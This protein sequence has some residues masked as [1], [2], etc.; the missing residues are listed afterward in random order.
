MTTHHSTPGPPLA[1]WEPQGPPR[2]S[3]T[4][5]RALLAVVLVLALT[6]L[7]LYVAKA[8]PFAR[9]GA[10]GPDPAVAAQARGFLADWSHDRLDAAGARTTH[11]AEASR[12][13]GSFTS[14]LEI[15][16]PRLTAGVPREAEGGAVEVPFTARMPVKGLGTW[17][18]TSRMTLRQAKDGDG[19]R[20]L[21][22]WKPGLV[23]PRLSG[24]AKFRLDREDTSE[25][26]AK[27]RH[28]KPLTSAAAPSLAPVL[29]QLG[30]GGA[31]PRGAIRLV[32]RTSGEVLRTE[33]R[34][35]AKEATDKVAETTLDSTW[36]TAA[37]H[38]LAAEP[39]DRNASLVAL[40]GDT[41]EILAVA[42][43]PATGFNR[44]VSGTYAPGST[45][46][47]VTSSALL[48]KGVVRPDTVVDCPKQL[49][50]GKEFHN[51]ETSFFPDA[52]FRKDF[53][54]SC[55]TAFISL[56][57][58]LAP[59]ALGDVARE[60]Y[61][62]GQEW[63][64]GVP[65]YDGSV[66]APKDETEKAA[67]MIGQ[68][69]LQA[70]PLIM[71]SVTATATTGRF[72]MPHLVPNPKDTTK[73]TPLPA[74][75]TT[76]LRTLMRAT[77]TE[78]TAH[79]LSDLPGEIGGKTGTAEVSDDAPNNG[80]M[81]ARRGN[82]AIACVVEGGVTGSGSAGPILHELLSRVPGDGE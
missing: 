51:V 43:S 47:L 17:T 62:I 31:G 22:D 53:T 5:V 74:Q 71:A 80:W 48:M 13:L 19:G 32:D 50:V 33:A 49:V 34:F 57:D 1:P 60:Y 70:N 42:N 68:A 8:G 29:A 4:A 6:A 55:N 46:K 73:T 56:R 18:Y 30:D 24:V 61:G 66:P 79:I 58:K 41:G 10:D 21:V 36:Q 59:T 81:V 26:K 15:T 9:P 76:D 45:F 14:G 20:W 65:S 75:V 69:R 77:V 38:A 63:H 82:V 40:R 7:G 72:R 78:G 25:P 28:G 44:A 12:I 54:E 64:I 3:R 27:D 67:S 23:H 11:P 37:E 39:E 16:R 35:G 2:R 52:T